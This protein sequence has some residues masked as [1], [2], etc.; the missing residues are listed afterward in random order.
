MVFRYY[1]VFPIYGE[2]EAIDEFTSWG[3]LVLGKHL[4]E[5]GVSCVYWPYFRSIS[6]TKDY[7]M[8]C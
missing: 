2:F 3:S 4:D 7:L 8:R 6:L 1:Y 5:A